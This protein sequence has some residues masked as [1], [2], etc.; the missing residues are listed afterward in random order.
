VGL[1]WEGILN[2]A[3][4]DPDIGPDQLLWG[5]GWGASM[6]AKSGPAESPM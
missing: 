3:M 6:V 5:T 1:W 2:R 4:N